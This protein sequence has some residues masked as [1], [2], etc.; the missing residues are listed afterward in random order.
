MRPKAAIILG[1]E[2]LAYEALNWYFS[3]VAD[4]GKSCVYEAL[5]Y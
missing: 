1:L 5:S 3:P 4:Y 2:L